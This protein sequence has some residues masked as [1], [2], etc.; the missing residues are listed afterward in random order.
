MDS[1]TLEFKVK[2]LEKIGMPNHNIT[3]INVPKLAPICSNGIENQIKTI[4]SSHMSKD[5]TKENI[6]IVAKTCMIKKTLPY[7]V[8]ISYFKG[9]H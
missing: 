1:N 9:R 2:S 8:C 7:N 4:S 6:L 3:T 5:K